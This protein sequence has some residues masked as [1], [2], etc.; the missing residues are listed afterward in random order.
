MVRTR[1]A[2]S[3]AI[4][5]LVQSNGLW[6]RPDVSNCN[7]PARLTR[8]MRL[9]SSAMA[10]YSRSLVQ[11]CECF[12]GSVPKHANWTSLLGLANQTLT[13]PALMELVNC[14][15]DQIPD[16]VCRYIREVFE[17]NVVR[18]DRLAAQLA[19]TVAAI[20]DQG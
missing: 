19:E 8:S 3:S 16:D 12:R 6:P 20:N 13:T 9:W 17:R 18:N 11:L 4:K 10:N 1:R 15:K 14:C 7:I 2:E 5:H